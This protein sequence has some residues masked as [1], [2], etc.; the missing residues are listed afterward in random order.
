MIRSDL[1]KNE[2]MRATIILNPRSG[3]K[4][5]LSVRETAIAM[6]TELGVTLTVKVIDGPGHGTRLAQDAVASGQDRVISVG[7]DGTLNA[8]AAGLV[9]TKV[10]LGIVSMGSGNGYACSQ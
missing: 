1:D 8:I 6:A 3:K 5:A 9:G 2:P 10:P 4:R 7:G